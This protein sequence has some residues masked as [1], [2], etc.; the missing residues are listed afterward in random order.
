M[1]IKQ[2]RQLLVLQLAGLISNTHSRPTM[3]TYRTQEVFDAVKGESPMRRRVDACRNHIVAQLTSGFRVG[4]SPQACR[5]RPGE[6]ALG[7]ERA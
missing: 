2:Q 1:R 5:Y 3:V 7:Q 6:T 4:L